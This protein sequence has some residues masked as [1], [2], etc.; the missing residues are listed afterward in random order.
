MIAIVYW[1]SGMSYVCEE[2][3]PT[4]KEYL[5]VLRHISI[6]ILQTITH[7]MTKTEI[8]LGELF[9]HFMAKKLIKITSRLSSKEW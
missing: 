2:M 9:G 5:F 3:S 4:D 8:S 6:A 7:S 1:R